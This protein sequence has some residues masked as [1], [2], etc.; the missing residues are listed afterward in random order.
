MTL[1]VVAFLAALL[2]SPAAFADQTPLALFTA[3][4]FAQAE[5]AGESENNTQG[6][7]IAARAALAD[8]TMRDE[9]CLDCIKHAEELSRKAIA[10][11]PAKPEGHIYLAAAIGYETR[12]IGDFA[13]QTKGYAGEAK[14]Q[15]DAALATDPNNAWALAAL[16]SW[17][18]EIVRGAGPTLARWLFGAKFETG[19]GL[20]EKAF[21]GEPANLI[22]HYQYALTLAA[23]DLPTFRASIESELGRAVAQTPASA[24]ET[25]TH[26]RA[27]E[28]LDVLKRGD[29]AELQRLI[30]RDRGYPA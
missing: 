12:V 5:A 16:G 9:P 10:A 17:N 28:L 20:Y 1:R 11:D 21:S 19:K 27:Q 2:A 25:F 23:Y 3:G 6:L 22:L 14:R 26:T 8:A 4:N 7:A 13:A 24:Y 18:I 15:L 30:R 29:A